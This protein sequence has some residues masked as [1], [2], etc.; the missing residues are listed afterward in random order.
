MAWPCVGWMNTNLST[1]SPH[2]TRIL[3]YVLTELRECKGMIEGELGTPTLPL[4]PE[5]ALKFS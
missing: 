2:P 5:L 4:L 1:G 3:Y